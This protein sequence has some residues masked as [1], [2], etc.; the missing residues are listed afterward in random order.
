MTPGATVATVHG[1]VLAGELDRANGLLPV[2]RSCPVAEETAARL[3][4]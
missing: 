4:R 3:R 2:E 1:Q